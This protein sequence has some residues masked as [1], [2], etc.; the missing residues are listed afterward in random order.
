MKALY[1]VTIPVM[2]SAAILV[3]AGSAHA[4]TILNENWTT[5]YTAGVS[6]APLPPWSVS[7]TSSPNRSVTVLNGK[8]Y[9]HDSDNRTVDDLNNTLWNPSLYYT[10]SQSTTSKLNISLSFR[11]SSETNSQMQFILR[12]SAGK[13]A[14]TIGLGKSFWP[15][16]SL[17][18][19]DGSGNKILFPGHVYSATETVTLS[20][21][22]IDLSTSTFDIA[23]STDNA[24]A[25]VKNGVITGAAFTNAV[26]NFK[27]IRF[28]DNTAGSALAELQLGAVTIETVPEPASLSLALCAGGALLARKVS[29]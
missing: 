14:L 3:T 22:N 15:T 6:Q 12:D 1:C 20:L 17:Y 9:Y 10:F 27:S 16:N 13:A 19:V 23:W 2:A 5:G 26:T 28:M 24:G 21:T 25:S 18:Y 11:L 29:R 8:I 7:D 4:A